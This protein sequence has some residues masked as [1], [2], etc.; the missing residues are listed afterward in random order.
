MSLWILE[1]NELDFKRKSSREALFTIGNGYIGC[2]GFFEEEVEGIESLGGIYLAGIFGAGK[3]DAWRGRSRE[4]ANTPNF[5]YL[6][7]CVDGEQVLVRENCITDFYRCLD[8][9]SGTLTRSFVWSSSTGKKV[10]IEF[11]RFA[12]QANVHLAGQKVMITPIGCDI[13]LSISPSINTNISNLNLE[14]CEPLPIQPGT[15]HFTVISNSDDLLEIQMDGIDNQRIAE[16]QNVNYEIKSVNESDAKTGYESG[17]KAGYE[18]GAKAGCESEVSFVSGSAKSSG[19]NVFLDTI[20][21]GKYFCMTRL[22]YI[23]STRDCSNP[24]EMVRSSLNKNKQYDIEKENHRHAWAKKWETSDI[25]VGDSDNDQIAVRYNLFQLMQACPKDDSRLSI[26]AR[27]LTGEMYEGCVFWDTEIF[28]LPFFIFTN[29]G[30]ARNLLEF[31]YNC[32]PNS[33]IHAKDNWFKGAMYAWQASETGIEQTP[34]NVGA[35]YAIHIVC[36]I[37]YAIMQYMRATGDSSFII[38]YGAEILIETARFWESRVHFDQTRGNYNILAVRGPNEYDVIV[39]NNVYTNMM[40]QENLSGAINAID[41]LK[42]KY[43]DKWIELSNKLE[44]T[45]SEIQKWS[46]IIEKIVICY[47]EKSDLYEEDDMYI[48]R[49]PLDLKK[50]KPTQK[51]II[52]STL[53]YEALP[54]Y[55]VTKQADVLCLMNNLSWRFTMNQKRIAFDY[56]EPKTAHDSSLS[57]SSHCILAA[58]VGLDDTAYEYFKKCAYLDINDIQLN[59]ISGLHFANFGGTWQS[60]VYGFGGIS[61]SD[62]YLV[63]EPRK[64][65]QWSSLSFKIC[66]KNSVLKITLDNESTKISLQKYGGTPVAIKSNSGLSTLSSLADEIVLLH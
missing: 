46:E 22:V 30:D 23:Y 64:P 24:A 31:R 11:E 54:L 28:K 18:S 32:L 37:A 55:Q 59:T 66:Y 4:L 62:E 57:Y 44:F 5:F 9:Q 42:S 61:I 49:V 21:S 38:D 7:V 3:Y 53:P 13:Y 47:D 19:A 16:G 63:I 56:Y 25:E 45:E 26:G 15:K 60:I 27:G 20:V 29:P 51:R 6:P 58:R 8:M 17:A 33:K 10:K 2:R 41:L 36:D 14:S 48:H 50:A 39:H 43:P 65:A 34:R 12:S 35:F 40:V 52:D 1:E